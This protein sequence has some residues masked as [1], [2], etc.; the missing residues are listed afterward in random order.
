[1]RAVLASIFFLFQIMTTLSQPF[2][3]SFEPITADLIE[4]DQLNSTYYTGQTIQM[5]WT[6]QNFTGSDL[7]RIQ[8]IGSGGTRTL[9]TGSG[10]QSGS[11]STRLSSNGIASNVPLTISHSTNTTNSLDSTNRITVIQSKLMNLA[12]YNNNLT[13]ASGAT[14]VC[15]NGNLT[16]VWRGLGQ[17]QIGAVTV[18]VKSTF[19][20]GTTVGTPISGLTATG[21]MTVNYV[22]PRSFNPSGF[23]NYAATI[24][25]QESGQSAYTITS[26][27]FKL[28]AAPSVT[29]ST[30]PSMTPSKTPT[31]SISPSP[32]N[33]PTPSP[34]P[35]NTPSPSV[36][37]SLTPTPTP[38]QTPTSSVSVSSTPSLST[39][40]TPAA[41]LDL[42]AIAAAAAN[43]VDTSTPAIAGAL[44][45]IGGILLILSAFKWY[46]HK[47]MTER[48]KKRLA[49]SARFVREATATYGLEEEPSNQTIHPNIVMY[50]VQN[51]PPKRQTKKGFPGTSV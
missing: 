12:L 33:T 3:T 43:S 11:F 47:V 27:T 13:V 40:P 31:P 1:M 48:R 15:D 45:G 2:F 6:S 7:A 26:N 36:T 30:T 22:L 49:M 32:S 51:M 35:S 4:W 41:S 50:T 18:I 21:N 17:A 25:V 44:G 19:G 37:S 8:Y 23:S 34:S 46:Q 29:P 5:N 28:S 42:A 24:T 9:T 39:S 20:S 10:I 38:T 16:V 14:L